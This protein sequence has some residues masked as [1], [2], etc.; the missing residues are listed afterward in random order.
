MGSGSVSAEAVTS[1]EDLVFVL[2][3]NGQEH[4]SSDF[5]DLRKTLLE[6]RDIEH[7]VSTHGNVTSYQFD[8]IVD[9]NY[10]SG[11]TKDKFSKLMNK[12]SNCLYT[13]YE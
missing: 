13:H 5:L 8:E 10:R 12:L 2:Q 4:P 1:E 9:R 7:F 11:L 6:Q 3:P